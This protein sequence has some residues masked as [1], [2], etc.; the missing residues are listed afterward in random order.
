MGVE[1]VD[2]GDFDLL[3][4]FN[5][6]EEMFNT[7]REKNIVFTMEP[8]WSLA[9]NEDVIDA[10]LKVFSSIDKFS[11]K[12][13]VEMIP[14]LMFMEDSGGSTISHSKQAG[15]GISKTMNDFLLDDCFVK[16]RKCSIILAAHRV[17]NPQ[18]N[19]PGAMYE[20]RENLLLQILKSDLDIDIYGR[21]WN[22]PDARY[23]GP[24]KYK[25]DALRKYE[26]TIAL[27]NSRENYYLSEK[28]TDCF[29]YNCVPIYDGCKLV[30]QFYDPQS[31][32]KIDM[33]SPFVVEDI[34]RILQNGNKKY[35]E[36]VISSKNKYFK[37]YNIYTYLK[38]FI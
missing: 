21:G 22:I 36:H 11:H 28:L 18:Y 10:S 29:V 37:D 2:D 30:H 35:E 6:S 38:D 25:E 32:E 17:I 31:F 33:T 19:D 7:P 9:A 5:F 4:S 8:N 26:F 34:H 14:S 12:D 1:V 27:E 23:K 15:A 3:V 16:D 20:H 13:N 24:A